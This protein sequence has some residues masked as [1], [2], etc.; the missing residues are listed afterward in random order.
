[1]HGERWARPRG[2]SFPL[3]HEVCGTAVKTFVANVIYEGCNVAQS[4]GHSANSQE[5]WCISYNT[6]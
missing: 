2:D 4:E 5:S 6:A 1:V 3:S